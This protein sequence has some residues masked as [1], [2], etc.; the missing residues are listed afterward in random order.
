MKHSQNSLPLKPVDLKIHTR[1]HMQIL[2]L[3]L[4]QRPLSMEYSWKLASSIARLYWHVCLPRQSSHGHL[5]IRFIFSNVYGKKKVLDLL[6]FDSIRFICHFGFFLS[7]FLSSFGICV[8]R[9]V[10]FFIFIEYFLID[11]QSTTPMALGCVCARKS[12]E[13]NVSVSLTCESLF[14]CFYFC[15]L[16]FIMNEK[17]K[18][19]VEMGDR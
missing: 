11:V 1:T 8:L 18:M 2:Y 5:A 14:V 15:K 16:S 19:K 12:I 13:E 10:S 7:F 17:N 3:H 6:P 9:F 4:S